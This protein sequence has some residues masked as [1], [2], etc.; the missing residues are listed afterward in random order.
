MLKKENMLSEVESR[1]ISDIQQELD[2]RDCHLHHE[3]KVLVSVDYEWL[4][5]I[6]NLFG[7]YRYLVTREK[8]HLLAGTFLLGDFFHFF[9][10][11]DFFA[12]RC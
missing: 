1:Q 2:D 8:M 12:S 6:L 3:H 7:E 5:G 4:A 9:L 11:P 10:L